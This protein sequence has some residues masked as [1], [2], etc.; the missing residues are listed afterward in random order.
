[1]KDKRY[2][3]ITIAA[4]LAACSNEE[5]DSTTGGSDTRVALTLTAG[6]GDGGMTITTRAAG[7]AWTLGDAIGVTA[8]RAGTTT[9]ITDGANVEY[10]ASAAGSTANGTSYQPLAATGEPIYLPTD[11]SE[12]DVYACYPRLASPNM[13]GQTITIS[14]QSDQ[15]AIDFMVTGRTSATTQGG[16]TAITRNTPNCQLLFRHVLSKIQLNIKAGDGI[17]AS[18]FT[19]HHAT[20]TIGEG[21]Y[22]QGT[23]NLW[24]GAISDPNS[25]TTTITPH[26]MDT[27]ATGYDL[28]LEAIVLPQT[29]QEDVTVTIRMGAS[30]YAN[31]TFQI[32]AGTTFAA[33]NRYVYDVTVTNKAVYVTSTITD[34]TT[35]SSPVIAPGYL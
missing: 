33:G 17:T 23:L 27:P 25:N 15:E 4:L 6:M 18:D 21:L 31:Y 7:D 16:S 11:Y 9:A 24:T 10:T 26:Q 8:V 29:T 14:N 30:P 1:M 34:W 20:V 22:T 32:P 28:S 2:I 35:G 5:T 13:F 19:T 3:L 12:V